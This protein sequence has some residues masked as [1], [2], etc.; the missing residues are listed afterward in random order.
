MPLKHFYSPLHQF[1]DRCSR[2]TRTHRHHFSGSVSVLQHELASRINSQRWRTFISHSTCCPASFGSSLP[3]EL[4][5]LF[6]ALFRAT[7]FVVFGIFSGF[8]HSWSMKVVSQEWNFMPK[9][10]IYEMFIHTYIVYTVHM[11]VQDNARADSD[12]NSP[13]WFTFARV[14]LFLQKKRKT[15]PSRGDFCGHTHHEMPQCHFYANAPMYK[16]STVLIGETPALTVPLL[17]GGCQSS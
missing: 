14:P 7:L 6:G 9:N 3:V 16:G 8:I 2:N 17:C 15:Y 4:I 10:S 12:Q 1:W 11:S 5:Q 13:V